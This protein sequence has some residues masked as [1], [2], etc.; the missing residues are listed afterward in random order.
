MI[1]K[2]FLLES[3]FLGNRIRIMYSRVHVILDEVFSKILTKPSIL[4]KL[5]P[6]RYYLNDFNTPDN[7]IS[8]L[9]HTFDMHVG[10]LALGSNAGVI[11]FNKVCISFFILQYQIICLPNNR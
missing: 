3:S 10:I 2:M 7:F 9:Q 6:L 1:Q 8:A 11:P 5:R 4:Q